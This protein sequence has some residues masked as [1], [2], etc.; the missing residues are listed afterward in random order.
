MRAGT[1]WAGGIVKVGIAN[2]VGSEHRSYSPGKMYNQLS[3]VRDSFKIK[4]NVEEKVMVVE[5]PTDEG[6]KKFWSDWEYYV[7]N[8]E[9]KETCEHDLWYSIYNKTEDGEILTVDELAGDE[10]VPSGAGV[11]QQIPNED[12][13]AFMTEKKLTSI[14][15][16][17][18]Y[19]ASDSD[20]VQIE[21]FTGIGGLEEAHNAMKEAS[22]S[23]TIIR[24][25]TNFIK[26]STGGL[27]YGNYFNEYR[28]VDGH[29]VKFRYLPMLDKGR[30][31]DISKRHPITNL[32]IESY[33][34][35]FL[36]MSTIDGEPNIQYVSERGRENIEFV[37]AGAKVP[38]SHYV[39]SAMR[40]TSRDAS[41]VEFMKSQGASIKRPTN[42]FKVY[43]NLE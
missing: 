16:N 25:N 40:A 33:S 29:V 6:P 32:P 22:S 27:S 43:C 41:S 10:F 36:D 28:H 38:K 7:R 39:E 19:N 17:A 11:I 20:T 4:G 30:F 26:N 37:V 34:M 2:S 13:Y 31:A 14:M 12:G 21:V 24:D 42:C 5:I 3:V 18:F 23:F 9:W 35:Y 8:L 1:R 15:R